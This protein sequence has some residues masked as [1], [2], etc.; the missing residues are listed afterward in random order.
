[1]T[2]RHV[3]EQKQ[4][5]PTSTSTAGSWQAAIDCCAARAS[6]PPFVLQKKGVSVLQRLGLNAL[7]PY[8][9]RARSRV[10]SAGRRAG[11]QGAV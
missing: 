11:M 6:G 2:D 8:Q 3:S 7:G 10:T 9:S 5:A 4:A 1:M